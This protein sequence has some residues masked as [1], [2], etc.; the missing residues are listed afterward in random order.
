MKRLAISTLVRLEH[1]DTYYSTSATAD[2]RWQL[3]NE[4]QLAYPFN[5]PKVT[6]DGA[7]FFDSYSELFVPLNETVNGGA[8]KEMR[9]RAGLG[10]RRSFSWRAEALY[11]L[12]EERNDSSGAF[13][14]DNHGVQLRPTYEF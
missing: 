4:L 5:R 9:V 10:Y 1:E 12:T 6:A 2:S 14:A 3:R 11:L 8:V 7:I 13:L